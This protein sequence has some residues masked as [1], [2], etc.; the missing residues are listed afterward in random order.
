LRTGFDFSGSPGRQ[1]EVMARFCTVISPVSS[2]LGGGALDGGTGR[3][4]LLLAGGS[5]AR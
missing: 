4:P 1:R 2:R 5:M 3:W